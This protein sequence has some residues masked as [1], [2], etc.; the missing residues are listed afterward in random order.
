M[1]T[2][3]CPRNQLGHPIAPRKL[4]NAVA[5]GVATDSETFL[6]AY[7]CSS[8]GL[9]EMYSCR[10]GLNPTS[11]IAVTKGELRKNGVMPPKGLPAGRVE[12]TRNY[13]RVPMSRLIATLGIGKYD[14]DAPIVDVEIKSRRLS[15]ML[16]QSIGTPAIPTVKVGDTVAAGD[17]IGQFTPDKL[18]VAIHAPLAG[19]VLEVT[20]KA[21]ILGI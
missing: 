18:G 17:V 14:V 9:C 7:S 12:P 15:V 16:S 13:R 21:V 5:S 4:M 3:L 11:M 20:D 19:R 2:D 8:C 1:C 6:G 10:Q